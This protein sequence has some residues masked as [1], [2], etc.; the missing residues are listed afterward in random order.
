MIFKAQPT[1]EAASFWGNQ[2]AE[3]VA[4]TC[5]CTEKFGKWAIANYDA[6][7]EAFFGRE[8]HRGGKIIIARES[9]ICNEGSCLVSNITAEAK[10]KLQNGGNKE[11]NTKWVVAIKSFE[12]YDTKP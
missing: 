9:A 1:S 6:S 12:L 10:H 3:V 4:A 11:E 7:A 5:N 8:F 2:C